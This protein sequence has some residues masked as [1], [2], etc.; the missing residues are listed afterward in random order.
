MSAYLGEEVVVVAVQWLL[1]CYRGGVF[2][3]AG[4]VSLGVGV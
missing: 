3:V 1:R 2:E 4:G